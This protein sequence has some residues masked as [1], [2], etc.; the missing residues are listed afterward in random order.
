MNSLSIA[1]SQIGLSGN[2]ARSTQQDQCVQLLARRVRVRRHAARALEDGERYAGPHH[3]RQH[4]E[5]LGA[6]HHLEL[7]FAGPVVQLW[8]DARC[9]CKCRMPSTKPRRSTAW[10]GVRAP[11]RS[12]RSTTSPY[13][14]SRHRRSRRW[15]WSGRLFHETGSTILYEVT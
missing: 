3:L 11:T 4:P 5:S 12:P 9:S 13:R 8:W 2:R 10:S 14:A 15:L 1:T 6:T 7:R